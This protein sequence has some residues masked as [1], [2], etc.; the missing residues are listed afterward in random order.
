MLP[1]TDAAA[2]AGAASGRTRRRCLNQWLPPPAR[3]RL[4]VPVASCRLPP[5]P[6]AASRPPHPPPARPDERQRLH[7]LRGAI[8]PVVPRAERRG[9]SAIAR[10]CG[11][12]RAAQI[13]VQRAG[14]IEIGRAHVCT[15]VTNP[16]IVCRLL[17]DETKINAKHTTRQAK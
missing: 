3:G 11:V 1:I 15:P 4:L 5:T 16:H 9:I 14:S 10:Q 8:G 2:K 7:E 17:L 12:D 13:L 6:A